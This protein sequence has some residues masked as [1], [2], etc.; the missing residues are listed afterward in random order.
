MQK[1]RFEGAE[2]DFDGES[3]VRRLLNELTDVLQDVIGYEEARGFIAIVGAR[4]G[5]AFNAAYCRVA[6][7]RALTREE[8]ADAMVDLKHRIGGAFQVVEQSDAEILLENTRCPFGD[9]VRGRP[10]L[11]MMTSN[12][13]GRI[14]AE[15]LGYAKVAIEE[16]IATGE[17]RCLVR[18]MLKNSKQRTST[19][20]REY[21][22]VGSQRETGV[23]V[24]KVASPKQ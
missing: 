7:G 21:F 11:C 10:T 24:G 17:N 22:R 5:D 13:F 14:A 16:A 6:G 19:A 9:S 20:G 23:E 8:A 15:N 3:F 18:V 12:V 4:I 1:N 2:I